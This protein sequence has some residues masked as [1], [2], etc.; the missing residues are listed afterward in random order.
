M[1]IYAEKNRF[2]KVCVIIPVF[3]EQD[4]IKKSVES[5]IDQ[6]IKPAEVIYVNDNS[7]DNSKNIIKNLIGKC[8]WIRVI[9][10]KSFQQIYQQYQLK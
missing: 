8:E 10:H 4:F 2:M 9:D 3:N 5:L 1:I 7:T 6:T